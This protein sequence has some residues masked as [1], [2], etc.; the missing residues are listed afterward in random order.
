LNRTGRKTPIKS[1][2]QAAA[3]VQKVTKTI[4]QEKLI[5]NN[6]KVLLGI[7]GGIDSTALLFVLL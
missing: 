6:D 5:G 1:D 4:V 3:I 2:K 7:S